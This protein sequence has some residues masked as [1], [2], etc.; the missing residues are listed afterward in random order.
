MWVHLEA[1]FDDDEVVVRIRNGPQAV[2]RHVRTDYSIGLAETIELAVPA[3]VVDLEIEVPSRDLA[4]H[5]HF[6]TRSTPHL[7]I[8]IAPDQSA[9]RAVPHASPDERF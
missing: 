1:G 6:D 4:H 3:G 9:I 2:R 8:S 5:V 7:A